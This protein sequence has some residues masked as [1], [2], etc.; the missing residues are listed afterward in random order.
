MHQIKP[1]PSPRLRPSDFIQ[2][3]DDLELL[4]SVCT[5]QELANRMGK[6]KGNFSKKLN[7]IE[8]ITLRFLVDFYAKLDPL[9]T[10][11]KQG[12]TAQEIAE[13]RAEP[14]KEESS[15]LIKFQVKLIDVAAGVEEV[16]K[17]IIELKSGADEMRVELREVRTTLEQEEAAL[18]DHEVAIRRLE[19]A[20]FGPHGPEWAISA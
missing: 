2:F 16:R 7:G 17:E 13:E 18:A 3:R 11:V 4:L 6:D 9:I 12:A 19:V 20:V 8:P 10:W 1:F 5:A 15:I 14:S